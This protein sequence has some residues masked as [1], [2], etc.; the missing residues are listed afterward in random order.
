MADDTL[1]TSAESRMSR[2]SAL[3]AAG[4][5]GGG[6]NRREA[7]KFSAKVAGVA[8]FATP[9]VVNAFS[10]PALAQTESTCDPATDSDAIE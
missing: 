2:R 8:A 7:L 1:E 5:D 9:V 3:T 6:F 10:A 4:V